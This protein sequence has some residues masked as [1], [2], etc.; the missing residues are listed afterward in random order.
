MTQLF[1]VVRNELLV[2]RLPCKKRM[3]GEHLRAPAMNGSNA[4]LVENK[5]GLRKTCFVA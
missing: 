5:A 1:V 3:V 2:K 4:C